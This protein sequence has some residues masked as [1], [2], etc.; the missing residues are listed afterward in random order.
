MIFNTVIIAGPGIPL[1]ISEER[2]RIRDGLAKN[3]QSTWRRLVAEFYERNDR[4]LSKYDIAQM[5][6]ACS[7]G[8]PGSDCLGVSECLTKLKH[9]TRLVEK[10]TDKSRWQFQSNP[11][12]FENSSNQ[13]RAMALITVVQRDLAVRYNI[14]FTEGDYDGRDSRNLFL[15]GPLSGF[16]G[17]CVNLPVLCVAIGRRLGYP[18]WLVAT[19]EHFFVRWEEP[20]GERFNFECAGTGFGARDDNYFRTWPRAVSDADIRNGRLMSNRSHREELSTF[21]CERANCLRD[22]LRLEEAEEAMYHA[23]RLRQPTSQW[24]S[25]GE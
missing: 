15:Q 20:G 2:F 24:R 5:N 22:N 16:G 17:T 4:E 10:R 3:A 25:D 12:K 11:A 13:H 23:A 6:L 18:L 8:L 9:W 14:P 19:R 21:L 7:E 1:Q